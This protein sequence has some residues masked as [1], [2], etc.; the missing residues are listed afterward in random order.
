MFSD[1]SRVSSVL[2]SIVFFSNSVVGLV[3]SVLVK[4]EC[5]MFIFVV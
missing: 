4:V 1:I 3:C 5:G 2:S